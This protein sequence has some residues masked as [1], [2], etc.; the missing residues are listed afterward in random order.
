MKLREQMFDDTSSMIKSQ[1][2]PFVSSYICKSNS[3]YQTIEMSSDV[4]LQLSSPLIA[5]WFLEYRNEILD[6]D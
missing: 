6:K 4:I 2:L 3:R 5:R 1:M